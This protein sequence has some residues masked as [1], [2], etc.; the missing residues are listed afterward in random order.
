MTGRLYSVSHGTNAQVVADILRVSFPDAR[1]L[2]DT[3]YGK[4]QFY[5]PEYPIHPT[6]MGLDLD[7]SRARDGVG[8]FRAL[9]FPDGSFDVAIFDPPYIWDTGKT[10]PS[11]IGSRFGSFASEAEA[12]ASIEAGAREAWRVARLGVVIKVMDQIHNQRA[13]WLSRWVWDALPVE[14]YDQVI[15]VEPRKIRPWKRQLSVWRNHTTF[16]IYR[17]DGAVHRARRAAS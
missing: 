17:K 3:T 12:N 5:S 6:V 16:W 10:K 13:F 8:D 11:I 15:R 4:G 1:T 14:P 2:V 7:P 9:D